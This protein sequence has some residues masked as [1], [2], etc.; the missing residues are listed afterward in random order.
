MHDVKID[1]D[2]TTPGFDI[3]MAQESMFVSQVV[4]PS[5]PYNSGVESG[6]CGIATCPGAFLPVPPQSNLQ[7]H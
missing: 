1:P 2:I 3:K 5:Y 7:P 4:V 6:Q